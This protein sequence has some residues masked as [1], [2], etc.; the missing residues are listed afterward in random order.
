ML[1]LSILF[2][3]FTGANMTMPGQS[4]NLKVMGHMLVDFV[5][6]LMKKRASQRKILAPL[7]TSQIKRYHLQMPRLQF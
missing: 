2:V 3:V 7:R 6:S 1:D 4:T 5:K